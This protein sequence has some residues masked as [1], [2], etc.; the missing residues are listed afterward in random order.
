MLLNP[1]YYSGSMFYTPESIEEL[2]DDPYYRDYMIYVLRIPDEDLGIHRDGGRPYY[3]KA[4][5]TRK[6][7]DDLDDEEDVR[8]DDKDCEED[9]EENCEEDSE[10]NYM[11]CA[12]YSGSH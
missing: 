7:L 12:F 3:W 10:E 4:D 9:C 5:G 6:F 1:N 8:E 11:S 2:L